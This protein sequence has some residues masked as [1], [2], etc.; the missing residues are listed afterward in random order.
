MPPDSAGAPSASMMIFIGSSVI[1]EV[2]VVSLVASGFLSGSELGA[3]SGCR[4]QP[5]EI[6]QPIS[7]SVDVKPLHD[8]SIILPD[9]FIGVGRHLP[10]HLRPER[11][12]S[13]PWTTVRFWV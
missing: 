7:S 11:T 3:R 10:W 9:D 13:K 5:H 2:G 4:R 12:P 1:K 6:P 8:Q